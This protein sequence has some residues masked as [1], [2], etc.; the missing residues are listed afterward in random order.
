MVELDPQAGEGL[1]QLVRVLESLGVRR[2]RRGDPDL[3]VI[4]R[5]H[6]DGVGAE[7]DVVAQVGREQDPTLTVELD[8]RGAGED[9]PL[10]AVRVL[11]SRFG[12]FALDANL[13]PWHVTGEDVRGWLE[14][15]DGA[16]NTRL[17]MRDSLRAA[18]S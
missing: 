14:R 5:T 10:A 1:G 7:I 12:R 17:S 9:Q 3:G 13:S 15:L 8:F 18:H 6:D 11:L 2:P 16:P 4:A